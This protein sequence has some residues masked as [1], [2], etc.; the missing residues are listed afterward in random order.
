[1]HG[2]ELISVV[3][4]VYNGALTIDETLRSVRAQTYRHLE[5]LVVDDGSLDETPQIVQRH[6]AEDDRVRL[7]RQANGGVAAARN[8]GV[9][10]AKGALLAFVDADD[11]W[12][13][14]KIEKQ[15]LSL[16]AGGPRYALSYT[17]Y[18]QIDKNS[19]IIDRSCRP[20]ESGDVL[21]RM[22]YGNL[23]GNGSSALVRKAAVLEVGGFNTELR[24]Q[25]AQGCE[26]LHFYFRIAERHLFA[27]VPEFL[28]GYR[29]TPT[30]MSSDLI[31]MYRSWMLVS[32]EMRKR[33]PK[34]ARVIQAGTNLY[35]GGLLDSA[36]SFRQPRLALFFGRCLLMR[37]PK[38]LVR[39]LLYR[40]RSRSS[41][42][43]IHERFVIGAHGTGS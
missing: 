35:I 42:T 40:G 21:A 3:V 26:D 13:A 38:L 20:T 9:A 37:D 31:Q 12:S 17:W 15:V 23:V 27:L 30:N 4:P 33:Q 22:C 32:S 34:L 29:S 28:T 16:S 1:M 41:P 7:I 5:I 10:Q 2:D 19:Q 36:I 39:T 43:P 11:L 18:A 25:R 24:A 8:N 6:T 14:G